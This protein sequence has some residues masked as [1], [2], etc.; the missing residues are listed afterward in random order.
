[1]IL[2]QDKISGKSEIKFQ[3]Q[4]HMKTKIKAILK[5]NQV[6]PF[7]GYIFACLTR[8]FFGKINLGSS[9]KSKS[10]IAYGS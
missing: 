6:W 5:N 7:L 4:T 3:T 10:L 1:M 2:K 9:Y 8:G